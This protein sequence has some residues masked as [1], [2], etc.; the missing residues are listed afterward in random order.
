MFDQYIRITFFIGID[1]ELLFLIGPRYR[2]DPFEALAEISDFALCLVH[3][4]KEAKRSE[5]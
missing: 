2:L 4:S 3:S 5:G 1:F